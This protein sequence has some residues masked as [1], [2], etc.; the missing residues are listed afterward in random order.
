MSAAAIA[1]DEAALPDAAAVRALL[2]VQTPRSHTLSAPAAV[3]ALVQVQTPRSHTLSAPHPGQELR[4]SRWPSH[5]QA[6]QVQH[7]ALMLVALCSV[8]RRKMRRGCWRPSAATTPRSLAWQMQSSSVWTSWRC[9]PARLMYQ[10]T[11]WT[12][13]PGWVRGLRV[14]AATGTL[15]GHWL[16]LCI[17]DN[18][19]V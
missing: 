17:N 16:L 8:R 5:T 1:L 11:L 14:Q 6:T 10:N 13:V 19:C 7:E 2:Q 4:L 3:R 9:A 15:R 18:R 12:G